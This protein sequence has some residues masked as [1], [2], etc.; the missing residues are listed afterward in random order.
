VQRGGD[1]RRVGRSRRNSRKVSAPST[2]AITNS[3]RYMRHFTCSVCIN[4]KTSSAFLHGC[5]WFS[6]ESLACQAFYVGFA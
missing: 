2:Q 5:R 3:W 4:S 6:L 1:D